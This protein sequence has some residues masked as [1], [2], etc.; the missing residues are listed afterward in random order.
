MSSL[1]SLDN[2]E[3]GLLHLMNLASISHLNITTGEGSNEGEV[4]REAFWHRVAATIASEHAQLRVSVETKETT[5]PPNST[6]MVRACAVTNK[7]WVMG[8]FVALPSD[9]DYGSLVTVHRASSR[10]AWQQVTRDAIALDAA[11]GDCYDYLV[12]G[13]TMPGWRLHVVLYSEDGQKEGKKKKKN[14]KKKG[15]SLKGSTAQTAGTTSVTL[16]I[17][18]S[19]AIGDGTSTR[20]LS[21]TAGSSVA[22]VLQGKVG[23]PTLVTAGQ[24]PVS[25]HA[26]LLGGENATPSRSGR[27]LNKALS[28]LMPKVIAF[29]LAEPIP[30]KAS[31]MGPFSTV[32]GWSSMD[33][34]GALTLREALKAGKAQGVRFNS[35]LLATCAFIAEY[36]GRASANVKIKKHKTSIAVAMRRDERVKAGHP[37]PTETDLC[38]AISVA[39]LEAKISN[40]GTS[41]WQVAQQYQRKTDPAVK[42]S[43]L[44]TMGK[45]AG[46]AIGSLI[47]Q[48]DGMPRDGMLGAVIEAI[49]L[50]SFP[51]AQ[52]SWAASSE[53]EDAGAKVELEG[54]HFAES[55]GKQVAPGLCA[56][57]CTTLGDKLSVSAEFRTGAIPSVDVANQFCAEVASLLLADW[58][59][60]TTYGEFEKT[61]EDKS[62]IAQIAKHLSKDTK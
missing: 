3:L 8:Q 34:R 48:V 33:A 20:V 24:L 1:R 32:M 51:Y 10:D 26:T 37:H 27:L 57:W 23:V 13:G 39:E 52:Q 14:K 16:V 54:T 41:F 4:Q 7:R 55:T 12:V 59:D 47:H 22:A 5:R 9:F 50:G 15:S 36:L 38:C 21:Y 17:T 28:A 61:I 45:V 53:E 46:L 40:D 60:T 25:R 19:H 58:G 2:M 18:Y 29:F 56:L 31:V 62:A 30:F 11:K 44:C 6:E 35:I 42:P 43:T 49:N